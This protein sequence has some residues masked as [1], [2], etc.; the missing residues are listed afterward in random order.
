MIELNGK[1]N[2]DC[3][4][5]IDDLE[6]E[7]YS[8][9]QNILDD[10]VSANI[11]VRIMPDTHVSMDIVIGFTMPVSNMLNPSHI[12]VDIGCG[13]LSAQLNDNLNKR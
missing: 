4:I 2:K 8:L 10:E 1:Y 5:F 12:G 7:A 9:I 3:K 6:P 13:M 11:P